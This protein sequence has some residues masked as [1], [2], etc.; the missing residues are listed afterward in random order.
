MCV[1]GDELTDRE[2]NEMA[3]RRKSEERGKS[4][5]GMPMRNGIIRDLPPKG[6]RTAPMA[7]RAEMRNPNGGKG[8][9]GKGFA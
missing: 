9:R 6:D 3:G 5:M 8:G 1:V 7:P 2:A 4:G